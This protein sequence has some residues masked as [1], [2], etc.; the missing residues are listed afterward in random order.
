MPQMILAP[1]GEFLALIKQRC[2]RSGNHKF[3]TSD[4]DFIAVQFKYPV[5]YY[6]WITHGSHDLN[7]TVT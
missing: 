4:S 3:T 6:R 7:V 5:D 2:D 1:L